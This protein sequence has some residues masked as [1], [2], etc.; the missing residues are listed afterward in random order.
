MIN[1]TLPQL[2]FPYHFRVCILTFEYGLMALIYQ[3]V[4]L[5][6]ISECL[7]FSMGL[8]FSALEQ[9]FLLVKRSIKVQQIK[10]K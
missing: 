6:I 4:F 7:Y 1:G 5:I 3:F 9:Y 10:N 8:Y 2:N